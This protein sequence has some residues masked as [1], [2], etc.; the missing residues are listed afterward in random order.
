MLDE[1]DKFWPEDWASTKPDQYG[2][3]LLLGRIY[4]S[5][6]TLYATTVLPAV[7]VDTRFSTIIEHHHQRRVFE[8]LDVASMSTVSMF[9]IVWPVMVVVAVVYG[10]AGSRR[11]VVRSCLSSLAREGKYY[12]PHRAQEVLKKFWLSGKKQWDDC[13]D[14]P[15][16]FLV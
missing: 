15:H 3:W 13:F 16:M 6:V 5:A 4:Q 14:K 10:D 1:I 8:L 12:L 9:S 2:N 11:R 7:Y